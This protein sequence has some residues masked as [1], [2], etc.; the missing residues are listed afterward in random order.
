MP[1]TFDQDLM[2]M[3]TVRERQ[4][5]FVAHLGMKALEGARP[6]DLIHE[7]VE[8]VA[9]I[10]NVEMCKVLK[11]QP[12][13]DNLLLL[14]GVGWQDGLVGHA[15]VP[16]AYD[17]QA[18]F[19]LQN[20]T[21]V[22]VEDLRTETRFNGPDLLIHHKVVSGM[23]CIIG[24]TRAPIGVLGVHTT[25]RRHF[26]QHDVN[27]MTAVANV[28]ANA[29][30][31]ARFKAEI[32]EGQARL[33]AALLAARMGTW[34]V[35]LETQLDTRDANLN[36]ILGLPA[37]ETT[38]PLEDFLSRVHPDDRDDVLMKIDQAIK[39]NQAYEAELRIIKPSGEVAW[40]K[41][42]GVCIQQNGNRYFT[43]AV[44]D[45]SQIKEAEAEAHRANAMKSEF[46]AMMSHEIRTPLNA[47][48]GISEI[49][50]NIETV[51]AQKRHELYATLGS[52]SKA[53]MSLLNDLLD[54]S[55]IESGQ[56]QLEA[57]NF[58]LADVIAGVADMVRPKLAA[59]VELVV[60]TQAIEGLTFCSDESRVRQI[61]LNL[62]SNAA[63]FTD[64]GHVILRARSDAGQVVITVE[65]TG[66]GIAPAQ[67]S[68]VFEK[69]TQTDTGS[70]RKYEGT[71]LGLSI[72]KS[73]C[74]NMGGLVNLCSEEGRGTTFEVC[75]PLAPVQGGVVTSPSQAG[76]TKP[77]ATK[78]A[79]ERSVLL[80]EDHDANILVAKLLLDEV[81]CD[82]HTVMDGQAALDEMVKNR[83][84]YDLVLLD[85][86]MPEMDG[87]E[88][89]KRLRAYE[90]KHNLPPLPVVAATANALTGDK[91]KCLDA[92]ATDYLAKPFDIE[93][94]QRVLSD[95]VQD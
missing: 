3:E 28:L 61:V 71:G 68:M 40:I 83:D 58:N 85:M 20:K 34:R 35:D 7:A 55:K 5:A 59:G 4:Q 66:I 21:P 78:G 24:R 23:S 14:A 73:L 82:V 94:L 53:L 25:Q 54:I 8:M 88:V 47:I 69:F 50:E 43:G 84:R 48:V 67:H 29:L 93:D 80:V 1:E 92:G 87:Y 30:K 49:L 6:T 57:V 90:G 56:I 9:A 89:L 15:T 75:L 33:K 65:D 63:K 19:T 17:S 60:D 27:F 76:Q 18:G 16:A 74:E 62:A 38:Q 26:T 52:S 77:V 2:A 37:R 10:L 13:Y 31:N 39:N 64:T 81:G 46:L 79:R 22:I 42:R 11:Y 36:E 12:E 72:V 32:K 70:A 86:R 51:S 41:D 45:I 44:V 95:Q 91:Q